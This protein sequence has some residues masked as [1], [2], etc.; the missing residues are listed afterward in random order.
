M[1][2]VQ[3]FISQVRTES[4]WYTFRFCLLKMHPLRKCNT[5]YTFQFKFLFLSK[6]I[7]KNNFFVVSKIH[8]IISK[9]KVKWKKKISIKGAKFWTALPELHMRT[10]FLIFE[11]E[12]VTKKA[13][14]FRE[15]AFLC[16]FLQF[17][18]LSVLIN[19]Y[20]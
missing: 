15:N 18:L 10:I 19:N 20:F 4:F 14:L 8:T 9:H 16:P 5:I 3:N 2:Q 17:N 6:Y 13:C 11:S 12:S 7:I 1:L